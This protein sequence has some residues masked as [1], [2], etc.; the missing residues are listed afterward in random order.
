MPPQVL[1][2][3]SKSL[4]DV[5]VNIP[6]A[7]GASKVVHM[8]LHHPTPPAFDGPEGRNLLRNHDEIRMAA[9]YVGCAS[10]PSPSSAAHLSQR[11]ITSESSRGNSSRD[12]C[13]SLGEGVMGKVCKAGSMAWTWLR[14]QLGFRRQRQQ[15]QQRQGPADYLYDDKGQRG[16]LQKGEGCR[17]PGGHGML[18]LGQRVHTHV[19]HLSHSWADCVR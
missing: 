10:C 7:P 14:A 2:L 15:Q 9:D 1:R 16:G 17:D 12:R 19:T 5:P 4:W 8:L 3:S 13:D 6:L 18:H 11:S